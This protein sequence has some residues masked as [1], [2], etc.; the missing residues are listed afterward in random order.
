MHKFKGVKP[1]QLDPKDRCALC[2]QEFKKETK[3]NVEQNDK[4]VKWHGKYYHRH[5]YN[6]EMKKP[7]HKRFKGS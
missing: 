2:F 3:E 7:L 1:G 6:R 5:C 4:V